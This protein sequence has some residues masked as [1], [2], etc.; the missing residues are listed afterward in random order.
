[1][2]VTFIQKRDSFPLRSNPEAGELRHVQ[3]TNHILLQSKYRDIV[4]HINIL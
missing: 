1:M 3:E 2:C 4:C